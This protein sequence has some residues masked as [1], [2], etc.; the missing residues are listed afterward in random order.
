M[1]KIRTSKFLIMTVITALLLSSCATTSTTMDENYTILEP[2][3]TWVVLMEMNDF[4]DGMSDLPID[5]LNTK[6]M[7]DMFTKLGVD[8]N[9]ILV[10]K[11]DM[12]IKSVKESIAWLNENS[13]ENDTVFFYIAS[14]GS[15][16]RNKLAWNT[17]ILPKWKELEGRKK[18]LL[19]DSCNAGEFIRDQKDDETSGISIGAV[20][21]DELGWWGI[22]EEGLPIIGSIWVKYFTEA[23]FNEEADLDDN[24]MITINEAFEY[25][26]PHVQKYMKEE[27][28]VVKEFLE[29][30]HSLGQYPEKKDEYPNPVLYDH[31]EKELV[32]YK[33]K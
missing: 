28:F 9:N 21:A 13:K 30:Y 25:S 4:P 3:K 10:K 11:D 27:V 31:F 16:I 15:W 14:H 12:S 7:K 33:L 24:G 23:V 18:V 20:S 26:S 19:V 29:S 8:E 1:K 5:F 6:Q 32:L 22:E 2:A 17:F